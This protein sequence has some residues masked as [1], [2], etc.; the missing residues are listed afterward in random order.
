MPKVRPPC[1]SVKMLGLTR[2]SSIILES[3]SPSAG[4]PA[5]P[6]WPPKPEPGHDD[7]CCEPTVATARVRFCIHYRVISHMCSC[8]IFLLTTHPS[9]LPSTLI[10]DLSCAL[11]D[12]S[13]RRNFPSRAHTT[14]PAPWHAPSDAGRALWPAC[15]KPRSIVEAWH[16]ARCPEECPDPRRAAD[17]WCANLSAICTARGVCA[18]Q[19]RRSRH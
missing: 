4:A 7:E 8:L 1:T 11:Y 5:A 19:S 9:R 18:G 17:P 2:V 6:H 12:A 13:V 10:Y 14:C 16:G 3:I 15:P